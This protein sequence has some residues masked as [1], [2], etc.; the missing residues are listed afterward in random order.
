MK[1]KKGEKD[2]RENAMKTN[3]VELNQSKELVSTGKKYFKEKDYNKAIEYYNRA[4]DAKDGI[5]TK[6]MQTPMQREGKLSM[7]RKIT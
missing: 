3:S 1:D 7:K 5:M 4:I 2:Q 6:I